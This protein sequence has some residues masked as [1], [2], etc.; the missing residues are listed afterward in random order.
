[1]TNPT[2]VPSSHITIDST[3]TNP[4]Q[5]GFIEDYLYG[6][7]N[8]PPRLPTLDQL[9]VLFENPVVP[10]TIV[11]DAI[12]GVADLIETDLTMDDLT[13]RYIEGVYIRADGSKL[14]DSAIP[15]IYTLEP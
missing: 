8:Q 7:A 12:G 11:P 13:G 2:L 10:L 6:T 3:K 1:L 5:L 4:A 14:T 9:I 15:G